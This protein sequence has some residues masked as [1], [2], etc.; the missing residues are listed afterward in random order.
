VIVLHKNCRDFSAQNCETGETDFAAAG[1]HDGTG[2]ARGK[3]AKM[4]PISRLSPQSYRLTLIAIVMGLIF[5]LAVPPAAQAAEV[6]AGSWLDALGWQLACW[7][8]SIWRVPDPGF[9]GTAGRHGAR[10]AAP[11]AGSRR[12]SR[13]HPAPAGRSMGQ[14]GPVVLPECGTQT[15]PNGCG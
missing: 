10:P 4:L 13:A 9:R 11:A 3:E 14:T 12:A 8:S 1:C 7:S 6:S 5:L 2:D 15:D